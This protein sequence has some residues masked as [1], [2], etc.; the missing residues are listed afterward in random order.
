[1]KKIM[2]LATVAMM[3][4]VSQAAKAK[5]VTGTVY[6]PDASKTDGT[7]STTEMAVG[8]NWYIFAIEGGDYATYAAMDYAT[9]SKAV[10][11]EFGGEKLPATPTKQV[12]AL[13]SANQ[14]DTLGSGVQDV[15]IASILTYTDADDK[16]WYIANVD[17]INNTGTGT[18]TSPNG[19]GVKWGGTSGETIGAWTAAAVPEPTSGLLLLLG[20][21][22]LALRRRRA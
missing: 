7:K 8:A 17:Y 5:W 4:Y 15:W 13:G 6:A 1:M 10:W 19:M 11:D 2:I 12:S 16:V 18:V 22:G 14:T 20:V 9:G 21:A 3:A